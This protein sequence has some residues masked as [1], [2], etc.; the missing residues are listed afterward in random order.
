MEGIAHFSGIRKV[1]EGLAL[2]DEERHNLGGEDLLAL[3]QSLKA[4]PGTC[5]KL[6]GL[7][8][9]LDLTRPNLSP[10]H[11]SSGQAPQKSALRS[12][13]LP[14]RGFWWHQG[15]CPRPVPIPLLPHHS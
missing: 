11:P 4:D 9:Q 14:A 6:K 3:L 8:A 7:L 1:R 5:N 12:P 2:L 13:A 15:R 10:R